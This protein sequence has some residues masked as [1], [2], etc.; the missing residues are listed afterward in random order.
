MND[1]K[2]QE[3]NLLELIKQKEQA[4]K[5]LLTAEFIISL[6]TII[7]FLL[8]VLTASYVPMSEQLKFGLVVIGT[9]SFIIG[10]A[11]ALRI[12]QTAGYYKCAKCNHRYVPTYK[13]VLFAPHINRTRYMHC[14]NCNE[15]S[16]HKKVLKREDD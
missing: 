3:E 10:M 12:E 1:Y 11:Y 9:I 8:T 13:S 4:D 6:L 15:K 7:L 5:R 2:K 16:W 14:P